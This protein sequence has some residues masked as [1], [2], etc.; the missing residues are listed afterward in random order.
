[1]TIEHAAAS[2]RAQHLGDDVGQELAAREPAA[3]PEPD[4]DRRIEVA[5]R[6]VPDGV[7]HRQHGQAEGQRDAEEA[8]AQLGKRRRQHRAAAPAEDQPERPDELRPVLSH[9]LLLSQGDTSTRTGAA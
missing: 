9:G 3:G 5:A 4:R 7:G 1:M 6:D 2:D 8:D